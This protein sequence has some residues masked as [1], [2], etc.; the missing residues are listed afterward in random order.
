MKNLFK[1]LLPHL[2]DAEKN[3]N[4]LLCVWCALFFPSSSLLLHFLFL[5]VISTFY[6]LY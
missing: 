1:L 3:R 4:I 6:A 5:E 2:K